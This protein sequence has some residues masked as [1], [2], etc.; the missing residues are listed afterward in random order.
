MKTGRF[1]RDCG[2]LITHSKIARYCEACAEIRIKNHSFEKAAQRRAMNEKAKKASVQR[3]KMS[4]DDCTREIERINNERR[5]KGLAPL[6]Y[7]KWV[8]YYEKR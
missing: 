2:H 6:S 4:L 8:L 3:G 1:C 7:G 5:Q